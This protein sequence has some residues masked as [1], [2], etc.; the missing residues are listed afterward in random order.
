MNFQKPVAGPSLANPLATPFLRSQTGL[1][2]EACSSVQPAPCLSPIDFSGPIQLS[3]FAN[4]CPPL[5]AWTG[6]GR[7]WNRG[8]ISLTLASNG[9][10][11]QMHS[12]D[13]RLDAWRALEPVDDAALQIDGLGTSYPWAQQ[14]HGLSAVRSRAWTP[15]LL[16]PAFFNLW[17]GMLSKPL[18]M[19]GLYNTTYT[20]QYN[21]L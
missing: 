5:K 14:A 8:R 13:L 11:C 6:R 17:P 20:H 4:S 21:I 16:L 15:E 2:N 7:D 10:T 18:P 1:G 9:F 19:W 3:D 12:T